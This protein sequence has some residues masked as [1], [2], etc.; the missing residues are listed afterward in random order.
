MTRAPLDR[1]EIGHELTPRVHVTTPT[2]LVR[3]AGA[4]QDFSSIHFDA[5]YAQ[6]RGFPTVIVHGFLKAAFLAE[7]AVEWA[8]PGSW[9]RRFGAKY[10]GIDIVGAPIV[11][12]GRVQEVWR[13]ERRIALDL[14][15]VNEEGKTTTTATGMVQLGEGLM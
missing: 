5:N 1:L 6:E 14:W 10:Q 15:T 9:F 8:G 3:Y 13:P 12:R 7:L 11:C 4:A 2:Q